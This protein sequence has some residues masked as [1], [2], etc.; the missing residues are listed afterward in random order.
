MR[1]PLVL[2]GICAAAVVLAYVPIAFAAAPTSVT[3]TNGTLS[4]G[5]ASSLAAIDGNTL[6][7]AAAWDPTIQRYV[8]VFQADYGGASLSLEY[9]AWTT[10]PQAA[11]H[12]SCG[13]RFIL[14][15]GVMLSA[16]HFRLTRDQLVTGTKTYRGNTTSDVKVGCRSKRPFSL[17]FDLLTN[18]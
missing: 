10:G 16:G 14:E 1:P 6:D 18:D 5:D 8:A 15:D 3:V 11:G 9:G 2:V 4:S 17:R 12:S 7:I 13:F